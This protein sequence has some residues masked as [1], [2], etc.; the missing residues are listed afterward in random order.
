MRK[1]IESY[2]ASGNGNI[3]KNNRLLCNG[4]TVHTNIALELSKS[5]GW[6]YGNV[7]GYCG[8]S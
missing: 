2:R 1:A 6:A 3:S 8:N 7:A 4:C 5:Y